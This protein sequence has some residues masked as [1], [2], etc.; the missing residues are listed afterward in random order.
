M[1]DFMV[2]LVIHGSE[3]NVQSEGDDVFIELFREFFDPDVTLEANL[4]ATKLA[5]LGAATESQKKMLVHLK[6]QNKRCHAAECDWKTNREHFKNFSHFCPMGSN[7]K[8]AGDPNHIKYFEHF[9]HPQVIFDQ[10]Q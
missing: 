7:C 9:H 3:V 5:I 10:K 2:K 4:M 1:G 6:G 8:E